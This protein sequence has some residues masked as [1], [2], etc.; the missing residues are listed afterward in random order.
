MT[1]KD[2]GEKGEKIAEKYLREQGF[3]IL[4]KNYAR[5]WGEID[6]VAQKGRSIRFVE[7][8]TL[9]VKGSNDGGFRPEEKVDYGKIKRIHRAAETFLN[10][11]DIDFDWQI[12]VVAVLIDRDSGESRIEFIEHAF[13]D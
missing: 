2:I 8:K 9:V 13:F 6:I 5:P 12:D 7:V 11:H 10:D 1:N 4:A 3:S